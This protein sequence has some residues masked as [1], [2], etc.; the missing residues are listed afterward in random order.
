[1]KN[2]ARFLTP[3]LI[4]T[5]ILILGC[6]PDFTPKPRAYYRIDLPVKEYYALTADF[7][8]S[9]DYPVYATINPYRGKWKDSD[10]SDYWINVEFPVFHCRMHLT[11]KRVTGNLAAMI[12]DAHTYAFKHSIKADAIV[13][14][15]YVDRLH[16]VYGVIFDLKGN[17]AS[18]VQF[19]VTDS[20]NHFLRAALYFDSEPNKD[21]LAPVRDFLRED[22][23][24]MIESLKWKLKQENHDSTNH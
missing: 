17:T 11:Y 19:Y 4:A 7:P 5:L 14:T 3:W 1:M 10:T 21:S 8:Y 15:E 12:D 13:Q 20:L 22:M 9:F 24:R 18:P 16:S 2:S 6:K 23:V